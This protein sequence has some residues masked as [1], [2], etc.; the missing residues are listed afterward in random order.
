MDKGVGL[1]SLND[2]I[3]TTSSQGRLIFNIFVSLAEFERDLIIE[4]TQ[5]GLTNAAKRKAVAA[6]AL[7]NEGNLSVNEIA[8]NLI[9][10]WT[11]YSYM[12]HERGKLVL[13]ENRLATLG[14]IKIKF[15]NPLLFR[16]KNVW[17]IT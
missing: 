4:R 11:L 2:P 6:K 1:K 8:G 7:Y 13:F 12:R 16:I 5:E 9:S 15:L 3:D 10:K 14:W 17:C